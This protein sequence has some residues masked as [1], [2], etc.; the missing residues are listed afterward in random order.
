[1]SYLSDLKR[2]YWHKC[3][4]F[5]DSGWGC[6]WRVMQTVSSLLFDEQVSI[7]QINESLTSMGFDTRTQDSSRL[8]FADLG[9]ISEYVR[10]KY[11]SPSPRDS[12]STPTP[13]S[14][15]VRSDEHIQKWVRQKNG[16]AGESLI[17]KI[18]SGTNPTILD[19]IFET[20]APEDKLVADILFPEVDQ[21]KFPGFLIRNVLSKEECGL[22]TKQFPHEGKG[23]LSPAEIRKLYCGRVVHRFMSADKPMAQLLEAR[24]GS[25]LPQTLDHDSMEYACN[26]L[27]CCHSTSCCYEVL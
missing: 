21:S 14:K 17:E 25:W 11:C 27:H 3:D 6:G 23:Y 9:W 7:P 5:D 24:I 16:N 12:I 18:K 1:M 26:I 19:G 8:A 20:K 22:L 4:G 10:V 15:K 13:A 2:V